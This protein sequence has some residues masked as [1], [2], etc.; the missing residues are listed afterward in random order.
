MSDARQKDAILLLI[1]IQLSI[2]S[3]PEPQF[4]GLFLLAVFIFLAVTASELLRR[5]DEY[6]GS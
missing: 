1:G 6:Q 2:F 4:D 5:Y 3:L